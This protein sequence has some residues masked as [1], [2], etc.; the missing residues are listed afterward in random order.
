MK[1]L[2]DS[3]QQAIEA[4]QWIPANI[5]REEWVR[6]AMAAHAADVPF[7][8]FDAW[9]A[10]GDNY[11]ARDV[12]DVWRSIKPNGGI[13]VGTLFRV[14]GGYGYKAR[15]SGEAVN[16]IDINALLENS[17]RKTALMPQRTTAIVAT[18]WDSFD[19]AIRH[20]YIDAKDGI[21]DGL[22]VVPEGNGITIAGRRMAGWLAVPAYAGDVLQSLQF[23]PP[24]GTGKKLNLPGA[25]MAG[26]SFIV[27][28]LDGDGPIYVVEGIGTAWACHKATGRPASV[29]FGWG[30]VARVAEGLKGQQLVIVPDKG[31][32]ESAEKMAR[33]LGA[34]VA[35]M[36]EDAP[37][38]YDANDYATEYGREALAALLAGATAAPEPRFKPLSVE[39]AKALPPLTWLIK[40][41]LP[42]QGVSQLYGASMS[43]KTYLAVDMAISIA[44]G[45]ADWYGFRVRQAPVLYISL[46]G[47]R[48][49]VR[50]IEAHEI[51]HD[52]QAPDA[53]RLLF[54]QMSINSARDVED[55]AAVVPKGALV[56]ID[57]QAKASV[58]ADENSS[59]DM[60]EI[61]SGAQTLADANDGMV[62]LIAHTGK[63]LN[64]GVRGHSSQI[65][66]LDTAIV[67]SGEGNYR[68][69]RV[70]KVKDGIGGEV[71]SFT[72]ESVSLGFD[73]DGDE[74]RSAVAVPAGTVAKHKDLT[75][76]QRQAI[77][78]YRDACKAG[79]GIASADGFIGLHGEKWRDY[80]YRTST[81]DTPEAKK[82]AFQR[83]RTELVHSGLA[84]V[85]NDVYR[86]TDPSATVY[87]ADFLLASRVKP[88]YKPYH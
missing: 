46:E 25:P 49:F 5:P 55:L 4:L 18:I 21:A 23:I 82:K 65:A 3:V 2:D 81:A 60:G 29:A 37:A 32:E 30:N 58:G 54:Q 14:A 43:G 57:T 41:V 88:G 48:G 73:E 51:Y 24:P 9:S 71:K 80:F 42:A 16:G 66:A 45:R 63:D 59:R 72:L 67:V 1:A 19:P 79:E 87:E 6:V 11:N 75:A 64:K 70:E 10:T 39:E 74:I 38:N 26:A 78:S 76:G 83:A 50:R 47:K 33:D 15:A 8:Y 28:A 53:L 12:R 61:M 17:K 36:P 69:W 40:D 52:R 85:E 34:A 31:K 62:M 7:E 44:E 13:G 22:R 56:I 84:T 20:P 27:G 68:E 86:V 77:N 35:F